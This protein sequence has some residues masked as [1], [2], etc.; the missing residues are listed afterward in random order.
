[1]TSSSPWAALCQHISPKRQPD[2]IFHRQKPLEWIQPSMVDCL[3]ADTERQTSPP[4]TSSG[5]YQ[6]LMRQANTSLYHPSIISS[7]VFSVSIRSKVCPGARIINAWRPG[8][9][10]VMACSWRGWSFAQAPQSRCIFLARAG[11]PQRR[12]AHLGTAKKNQC[13]GQIAPHTQTPD[14][15]PKWANFASTAPA[16][17]TPQLLPP[18]Q[19]LNEVPCRWFEWV[20]CANAARTKNEIWNLSTRER[21]RQPIK[22]PRRVAARLQETN[23]IHACHD[24]RETSNPTAPTHA[25]SQNRPRRTR[26]CD[27]NCECDCNPISTG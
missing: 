9:Y 24:E 18:T 4:A 6:P 8:V 20:R 12:G 19:S 3:V 13:L 16:M 14:V 26:H 25:A 5:F 11:R 23:L 15:S 21:R 7:S 10:T 17:P 1:M 27:S 2:A 22:K